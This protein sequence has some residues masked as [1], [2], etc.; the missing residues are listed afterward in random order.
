LFEVESYRVIS[1]KRIGYEAVTEATVKLVMDGRRVISTAEGNQPIEA[2]ERALRQAMEPLYP[3]LG[4]L[5]FLVPEDLGLAEHGRGTIET[6][7]LTLLRSLGAALEQGRLT[8]G[9][10]SG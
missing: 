10:V 8:S 5:P 3:W 6:Q 2:L 4:D 1:E 9:V 7:W